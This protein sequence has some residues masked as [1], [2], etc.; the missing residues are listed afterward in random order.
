MGGGANINYSDVFSII[1]FNPLSSLHTFLKGEPDGW[2]P[3]KTSY[4]HQVLS[5]SLNKLI[6]FVSNS[7]CS[8]ISCILIWNCYTFFV[9]TLNNAC[10]CAFEYTHTIVVVIIYSC[11][12]ICGKHSSKG[13]TYILYINN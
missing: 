5:Q 12:L 7:I 1:R 3:S 11:F 13:C 10:G 8:Y 9:I 4:H 2:N 6:S